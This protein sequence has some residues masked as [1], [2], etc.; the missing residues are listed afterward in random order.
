MSHVKTNPISSVVS[1]MHYSNTALDII[2]YTRLMGYA[3]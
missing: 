1:T 3:S 2:P